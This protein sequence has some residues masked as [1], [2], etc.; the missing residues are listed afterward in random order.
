M[1]IRDRVSTQ[2][3]WGYQINLNKGRSKMNVDYDPIARL[4]KR[5]S[6]LQR[7]KE[8]VSTEL[9]MNQ[10]AAEDLEAKLEKAKEELE[11]K[12]AKAEVSQ[13]RKKAADKL[14]ED[15]EKAIKKIIETSLILEKALDLSLIH[16]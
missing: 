6:T 1:C 8:R 7:E 2:S 9:T 5:I 15:T 11:A 4:S 13:K 16:I 14:L 10:K 3:T 12:K